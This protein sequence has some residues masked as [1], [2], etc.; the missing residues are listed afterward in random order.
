MVDSKMMGQVDMRLRHLTGKDIM[1]GGIPLLLVGDHHQ[2][3]A[4]PL[5]LWP[6]LGLYQHRKL[7][8]ALDL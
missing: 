5:P 3:P 2:L 6:H 1:C 8:E 7:T 4:E